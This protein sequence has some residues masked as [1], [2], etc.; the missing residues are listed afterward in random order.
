MDEVHRA[1]FEDLARQLEFWVEKTYRAATDPQHDLVGWSD[2][3][4]DVR[5]LQQMNMTAE[6]RSAF[7]AVLFAG[8]SALLH[9]VLVM[10]DGGT[11]LVDT[12]SMHLRTSDGDLLGPGLHDR[13]YEHLY[14][15]QRMP[16]SQRSEDD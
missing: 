6:E 9:N 1:F 4:E 15:T 14:D 2:Y 3:V 13:F 10:L 12:F 11:E 5:I 16:Y 7:R 8:M